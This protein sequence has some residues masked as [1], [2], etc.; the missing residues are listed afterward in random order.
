[1]RAFEDYWAGVVR[2]VRADY[3]ARHPRPAPTGLPVSPAGTTFAPDRLPTANTVEQY[4]GQTFRWTAPVDTFR[5]LLPEGSYRVEI[6]T[7]GIR[8]AVEALPLWLFWNRRRVRERGVVRQDGRIAFT[9]EVGPAGAGG[10]Q[11]LDLVTTR[12][13]AGTGDRRRLGLPVVSLRVAPV[14]VVR[15]AADRHVGEPVG[16]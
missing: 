14:E 1:V 12:L 13:A 4:R 6:D 11:R 3:T 10:A 9:A 2:L 7:G 5:F 8:G 15:V 16:V